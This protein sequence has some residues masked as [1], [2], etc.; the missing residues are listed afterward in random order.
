M[1]SKSLTSLKPVILGNDD[2][3]EP[4]V[5]QVF[6]STCEETAV[7]QVFSPDNSYSSFQ[8]GQR[9]TSLLNIN[10]TP[11]NLVNVT[12][13]NVSSLFTEIT[14][15]TTNM[16]VPSQNIHNVLQLFRQLPKDMFLS[17]ILSD[18]HSDEMDL[19][20]LRN[21]LFSEL[22]TL[23]DFP[24]P[25]GSELKRRKK[26]KIGESTAVKLCNDIY[27]LASVFEGA[28]FDDM[29][30]LLSISKYNQDSTQNDAICIDSS[31]T[32]V[33]CKHDSDIALFRSML[34]TIQADVFTLKQENKSLREDYREELKSIKDDVI[35]L[36]T[37][38]TETIDKLQETANDC[39]QVVDRVTDDRL[40]GITRVKND[41]KLVQF[42]MKTLNENLDA[43][44][45]ELVNKFSL[46]PKLDK[47]LS[48]LEQ[49]CAI[50]K[51]SPSDY[52]TSLKSTCE[53]SIQ[54]PVGNDSPPFVAKK[55]TLTRENND[56][57]CTGKLVQ[58]PITNKFYRQLAD[59]KPTNSAKSDPDFL[60]HSNTQSDHTLLKQQP[61]L[62]VSEATDTYVD[63]ACSYFQDSSQ[64]PSNVGHGDVISVPV[65]NRFDALHDD[66]VNSHISYSE[67]L[68]R[69]VLSVNDSCNASAASIPVRIS[70]RRKRNGNT[71]GQAPSLNSQEARSKQGSHQAFVGSAG[72]E[73][74]YEDDDFSQHIR[75][76]SS[77][78]YIGGFKPS[79]T[80]MKLC[81][82]VQRRGVHVS[83]INIRRYHDQDRAV[84]Q[85]NVDAD[86]GSRL[87]EDGF[88]PEE[89]VC[90][91]WYPRSV[92]RKRMQRRSNWVE[93]GTYDYAHEYSTD[94]SNSLRNFTR[95]ID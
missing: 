20:Q 39:K 29:K 60:A 30:E 16:H 21:T 38:I 40:N 5:N 78:F 49:K 4:T 84:I 62:C 28:S 3:E 71:T 93:T 95:N 64:N 32:S 58:C 9:V 59:N 88:W 92:L 15:D 18:F 36:K 41:L 13:E 68:K 55:I 10:V 31:D 43:R 69:P 50:S 54:T 77:R 85:L 66:R 52:V 65:R 27:V 79:I 87:L 46:V 91:P 47:R 42:D 7:K 34:T 37:D 23:A 22:K 11:R 70:D 83:W 26:P 74:D 25:I 80:E 86:K 56:N 76:K 1:S 73:Q 33:S 72:N 8:C 17:Q 48:K 19:K 2:Y 14:D 90:R 61:T 44:C 75:R 24:F 6:S 81:S 12:Q 94:D 63:S 35:L 89:V 57:E 51:E 67:A 45:N 82:Y 53:A